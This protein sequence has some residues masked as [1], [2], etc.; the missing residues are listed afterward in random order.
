[1]IPNNKTILFKL[2]LF[3][4]ICFC[5]FVSCNFLDKKQVQNDT[6]EEALQPLKQTNSQPPNKE[7]TNMATPDE[8]NKEGEQNDIE[9][10]PIDSKE[11]T[12]QKNFMEPQPRGKEIVKQNLDETKQ[13]PTQKQPAQKQ[14]NIGSTTQEPKKEETA[15]NTVSMPVQEDKKSKSE[16]VYWE[17]LGEIVGNATSYFY[18]QNESN[19]FISKNGKLYN[20][21]QKNYIDIPFLCNNEGLN[22]AYR[23]LECTILYLK[24]SHLA[25]YNGMDLKEEDE[26]MTIFAATRHPSLNKYMFFSANGS[27]GSISEQDYQSLLRNYEQNH[28][29][30]KRLTSSSEEYERILN[31][32]RVYESRFDPYFVRNITMDDKYASVVFSSQSASWDVRQLILIKD[33]TFWEVVMDGVEKEEDPIVAINKQLP[34]FN[35][36]ILPSYSIYA[37]K[38]LIKTN[39]NDVLSIFLSDGVISSIDDV[40][41]VSGTDEFCYVVLQNYSR[42]VCTKQEGEWRIKWVSSYKEAY[43]T[44]IMV[45]QND[46]TFLLF[47][48]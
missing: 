4:G 38:S 28:G 18:E 26:E 40:Y 16:A 37:A 35:L 42:Y 2:I 20:D 11:E 19:R 3:V 24:G 43:D 34:D 5:F 41:Y 14:T 39:Y 46:L 1:M 15:K 27:G 44:M 32:I 13:Q 22:E 31:F 7:Q 12:E 17:R 45:G 33:G 36:N 10:E 8:E 30:M 25:Q 29:N 48:E 21:T 23:S 9:Q 47:D 6:K